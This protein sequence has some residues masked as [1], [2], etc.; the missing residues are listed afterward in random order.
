[1]PRAGAMTA[2]FKEDNALSLSTAAETAAK[3]GAT[4]MNAPQ[5]VTSEAILAAVLKSLEDDKGE[6]IVQI[7]LRGKSEIGDFMVIASGLSLI[8]I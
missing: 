2:R 7:N 5:T 1:M 4:A 3:S 8:H 6:D